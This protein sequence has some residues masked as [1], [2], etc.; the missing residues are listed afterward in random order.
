MKLHTVN[1]STQGKFHAL[2]E[3]LG[4]QESHELSKCQ[5]ASHSDVPT[6][7]GVSHVIIEHQIE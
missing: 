6:G 4:T 3:G 5:G 2:K 1:V 7:T